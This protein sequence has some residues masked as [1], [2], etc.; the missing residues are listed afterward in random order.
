MANVDVTVSGQIT[1]RFTWSQSSQSIANNN[2]VVS[3]SLKLISTSGS[4]SSSASKSWNVTVNGTNYSGT[5]TVGI[6]T[7][8]TK[9]LASGTTTIAH[10]ADGTKSF[11]FSFSQQFDISYSGVGW[12]GTKNG[13]GSGTLTT[14]PRTSSV[15]ATNANIGENITISINRASSSFTH[16]LSYSFC[17]L[18]GT[19]ATKTSSTSVSWTL[20]TSFYAQIPNSKSSW[21]T[22]TCDTYSGSTKIGSSTCRFNVY[23]KEST[24]KPEI[25]ATVVD[26]NATTKALTGDEN[27]II[28]YYST[29]KFTLTASPKNSA[30]ISSRSVTYNGKT[31]TGGS[32]NSW[33]DQFS[34]AVAGSFQFGVTDS[35]GYSNSVTVNKTLINYVKI[36]CAMTTSNPTASGECTLTIKGNYF[37]GSFGSTNNTLT[38]QYKKDSGSWTN[39]TA[40]LSGNTYT[41]TVKITGLDYTQAYTFQA[42]ATDKLATVTTPSK[43]IKSTPIFDWGS[44][45]FHFHVPVYIYNGSSSSYLKCFNSDATKAIQIGP[46]DGDVYINNSKSGKYLQLKDNGNLSYSD[47]RIFTSKFAQ[48]DYG[49]S[50]RGSN[51]SG[52]SVEIAKIASHGGV[53]I[54]NTS[55][56]T[57]ICSANA[58]TWWNGSKSAKLLNNSEHLYMNSSYNIITS[59]G[60]YFANQD[61]DSTGSGF[62]A[63]RYLNSKQQSAK[64]MV[65]NTGSG[66]AGM[67]H[68]DDTN[69]YEVQ[70]LLQ[71][72]DSTGS[73]VLRPNKSGKMY[74]GSND[75]KYYVVYATNGTINTSDKNNKAVI[76]ETDL[77]DCFDMVKNTPVYNYV[78][79][80][81]NKNKMSEFEYVE[82][83]LMNSGR[84]ESIQVGIMAQDILNYECSKYILVKNEIK[85]EETQETSEEYGINNYNFT[86]ALM[87]AL[88]KEIEYREELQS[89]VDEL[90]KENNDLK[91]RIEQIE[92]L[93]GL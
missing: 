66:C 2:S 26:T 72:W 46:G 88:K 61:G 84:E 13:G 68:R 57:A 77:L 11:S 45:N 29:A 83:T 59:G 18:N 36:T 5:N 19:I 53:D 91:L 85:D 30:T 47:D 40:T 1:L 93:L 63:R 10:N 67:I 81:E 62:V 55:T 14:I 39:A 54:G 32:G 25:S 69:G 56:S 51:S 92:T 7:N 22:I 87:G 37:N 15:S 3:W 27:K 12:I 21:G 71:V 48:V 17:N 80:S 52:T 38:V 82:D 79:L 50:F 42:R 74:L 16:T 8:S 49:T 41:A 6:G 89:K 28:K 33:T 64:L 24:N 44:D 75:Y 58:P 65:I 4:I 20:P 9:T 76:D 34:N 43:T 90:E 31:V 35:R 78:M 23:V 60:S 73:G 86:S 70:L